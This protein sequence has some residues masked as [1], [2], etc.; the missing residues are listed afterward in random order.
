MRFNSK[1]PTSCEIM[2]FQ[3][4]L[5]FAL[6]AAW[7]LGL[8]AQHDYFIADSQKKPDSLKATPYFDARLHHGFI[9]IHSRDIRAIKDSYPWGMEVDM[10]WL[11]TSEK[12]WNMCNCFPRLG[13]S[14]GF[15]EFDNRP[16]LGQA[17]AAQFFIEPTFGA[18]RDL[19][20]GIRAGMGLSYQNRPHH[21]TNNPD[22]LSYSTYLAFPLH[23]GGTLRYRLH[24]QWETQINARYNHISNGGMRQPNKGINWP[25]A[26]LG[27][28]YYPSAPV[29]RARPKLPWRIEGMQLNK[30]SLR[31]FGSYAE[32]RDED[33][34]PV[35]GLE[36]KFSRRVARINALS[37]GSEWLY[38]GMYGYESSN[39]GIAA[40][41]MGGIAVGHEFLLG[42]FVF[43]QQFGVYIFKPD[44]EVRDVYQRYELLYAFSE[45]WMAGFG[46]KTHG[47]VAD[48]LDIRLALIL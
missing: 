34:L 28:S 3:K 11:K 9:I 44:N 30:Q 1:Y 7:T 22:N 35:A 8:R 2:H 33:V 13:I 41:G 25:T 43:A 19:S 24:P 31:L 10:A 4:H 17:I 37:L 46:L 48:F 15:W 6:L 12:S 42:K 32:S 21:P 40:N 39:S 29:L 26:A 16:I 27:L 14:L 38:N 23:V 5:I 36:Y 47:H 45:K 18:Q 20:F